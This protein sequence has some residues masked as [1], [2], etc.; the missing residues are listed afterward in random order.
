MCLGGVV[1]MTL[2]MARDLDSVGIRVM[3]VAPGPIETP[4]M[5]M[6]SQKTHAALTSQ[7]QII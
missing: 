6:A 3:T 1:G 5:S 7:V 4:L 2:P